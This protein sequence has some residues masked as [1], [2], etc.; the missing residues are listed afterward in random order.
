MLY[1]KNV[2]N[3]ERFIRIALGIVLVAIAVFGANPPLQIG[4]L[5]F[6]AAFVVVTGFVGWCPA[7]AL[8]GRKLRKANPQ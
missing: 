1:P 7:C 4:I 2:P 8:I 6:T 5:L 3:W